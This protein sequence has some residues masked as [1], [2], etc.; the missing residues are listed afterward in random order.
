MLG[1]KVFATNK[2]GIT[3]SK[4]L[5][6]EVEGTIYDIYNDYSMVHI[7]YTMTK[8]SLHVIVQLNCSDIMCTSGY[9]N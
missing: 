5:M 6:F 3:S 2:I 7:I 9:L 4:L 1:A 8:T